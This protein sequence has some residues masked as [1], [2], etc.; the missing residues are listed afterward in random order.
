MTT[1]LV[2]VP[3]WKKK[4]EGETSAVAVARVGR[5]AL[6]FTEEDDQGTIGRAV[7]MTIDAMT[8]KR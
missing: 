7:K 6:L 1:K 3:H 5:G 4:Y 2:I 8:I